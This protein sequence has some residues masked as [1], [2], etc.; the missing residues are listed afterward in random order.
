MVVK[1]SE[2]NIHPDI[3][4]AQLDESRTANLHDRMLIARIMRYAKAHLDDDHM[5]RV[6]VT[7]AAHNLGEGYAP[8]GSLDTYIIPVGS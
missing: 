8:G 2:I 7:I 3:L 1:A 4:R 6:Y 5:K